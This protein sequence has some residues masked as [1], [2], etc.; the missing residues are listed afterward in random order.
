MRRI[1]SFLAIAAVA[2]L[3]V[4][5]IGSTASARPAADGN[6]VQTAVAAGQFTTLAALLQQ[7]GLADTLA[8]GGPFTV[9]APTDAAFAK[10]PP[11][12]L[13]ALAADPA[14]LRQVLL[15]H[16]VSGAVPAANVVKLTGAKTLNGAS[17]TIKVAD[18]A[19]RVDGATVTATD[20]MASNGI[21]HV[22]DS[23]LI[24][25][26]PAAKP[27]NIVQ[28]AVAAGQFKTLASL[29]KKAG[30]AGTLQGRGP[31]TVFAPT[32]AAFAKVPKATLA[33]L[34]KD[35]AKLRAVLLYHVV[36]GK[37]T[38]K[39]VVKLRS[40]KTLNGQSVAIRTRGGKVTVGGAAVTATDVASSNGVIH[41]INKVLIP[42]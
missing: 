10:V 40:A 32:D 29:L 12:T 37:V 1:R 19:V 14:K 41:V 28:T 3:A 25:K 27:K 23:V 30:L 18:G 9:F 26:A 5:A 13:Q 4:A 22:I 34:G 2:A 35:R 11:A 39:Q 20:V 24:P 6:I 31:F 21:I 36:K 7:T 8:G 42:R 15:Y 33:A 16:V 17:V 38:A